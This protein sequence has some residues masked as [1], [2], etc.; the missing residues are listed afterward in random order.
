MPLLEYLVKTVI[1]DRGL[2]ITSGSN[3]VMLYTCMAV[4][5]GAYLSSHNLYRGLPR[6]AVY[7]NFFRSI[8]SIPVAIA[9][10]AL[11]LLDVLTAVDS[12]GLTLEVRGATAPL[13]IR[14]GETWQGIIMPMGM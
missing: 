4:A 14:A 10:N 2:G 3:P 6:S 5:N 9:I 1:L 11:Y 7:G 12:V 13:V 8:V